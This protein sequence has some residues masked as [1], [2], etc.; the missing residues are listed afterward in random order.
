MAFSPIGLVSLQQRQT[1]GLS[2]LGAMWSADSG[3][4]TLCL[5]VRFVVPASLLPR[6]SPHSHTAV[7]A[8]LPCEQDS[9]F[10]NFMLLTGGYCFFP[11]SLV[12]SLF[13]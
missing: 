2:P 11:L 4:G 7:L 9:P 5:G 10:N 6:G 13:F 3:T 1:P 12:K 8:H